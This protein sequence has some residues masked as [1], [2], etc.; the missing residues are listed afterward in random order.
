MNTIVASTGP[1]AGKT[2]LIVG[3]ARVLGGR[4]GY[5]KPLGDR[6][7]YQKKRLWDYDAALMTKLWDL[8]Q[9][10]E[11]ITVGFEQAKLRYMFDEEALNARLGEMLE[12]AADGNDGVFIEAGKRFTDGSS[13]HLDPIALAKT[14]GA[15][16]L[17]VAGGEQD[18]I[19]D[20]LQFFHKHVRTKE[21]KF[22][23]VIVNNVAD[24]DDFKSTYQGQIEQAGARLLGV[25]PH[26]DLL[27]HRKVSYLIERLGARVVA[28]HQGCEKNVQTFF[29]GAM[30]VAGAIDHPLF[31]TPD[32]LI[33]TPGDRSD[34]VLAA[35]QTDAACVVIT[36]NIIPP[37]NILSLASDK[38]IPLLLVPW[39]TYTAVKKVE[40]AEALLTADSAGKIELI[41]QMVSERL[42]LT[43]LKS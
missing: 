30:E 22:A 38:K 7:L 6:L 27:T 10:P 3:I 35:I 19:L 42:D 5:L 4:Y 34:M 43:P 39:D 16:L 9:N 24:P 2:S 25:L 11:E 21:I 1:S 20:D 37:K 14:T 36:N 29:V 8:K 18:A 41:S 15:S 32:R 33:I 12:T 13:V 17:L 28:G 40:Q 31:A 26:N 23:G